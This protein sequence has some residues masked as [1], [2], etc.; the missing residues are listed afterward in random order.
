M[1]TKETI[2]RVMKILEAV[3]YSSKDKAIQNSNAKKVHN[4]YEMLFELN[5]RL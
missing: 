5:K 3:D 1:N 2:E 4:A